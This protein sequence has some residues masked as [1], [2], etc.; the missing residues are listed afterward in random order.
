MKLT[1][2]QRN[3]E[4]KG[5]RQSTEERHFFFSWRDQEYFI[6]VTRRVK[7]KKASKESVSTDT[8]SNLAICQ[9]HREIISAYPTEHTEQLKHVC[10]QASKH[11]HV[12]KRQHHQPW[13]KGS[14]VVSF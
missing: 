4:N 3:N 6:E 11:M 12:H 5:R 9:L 14:A 1:W 7:K 10:Q 2:N 13:D 8:V